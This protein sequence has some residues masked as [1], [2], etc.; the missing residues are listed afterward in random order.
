MN[1]IKKAL[2]NEYGIKVKTIRLNGTLNW[3]GRKYYLPYT[4]YSASAGSIADLL[5]NR[6]IYSTI[7]QILEEA[8]KGTLE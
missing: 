6:K 1:Y 8:R 5:K 4:I 3:Y 7:E 2:W